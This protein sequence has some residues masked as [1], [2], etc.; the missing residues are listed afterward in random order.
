[1]DEGDVV[2]GTDDVAECGEAFFDA[3]DF[4]RV[5]DAI[6]EVLELLVGCGGWD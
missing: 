6:A 3:L 4:Y 1:M 5:G 2:V